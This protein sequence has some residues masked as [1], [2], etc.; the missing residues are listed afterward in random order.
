[1]LSFS[2][3]DKIV[4]KIRFKNFFFLFEIETFE[5]NVKFNVFSNNDV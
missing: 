1:M 5:L 4:I 2:R 3:R